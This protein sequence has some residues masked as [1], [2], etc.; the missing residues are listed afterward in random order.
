MV[1]R[2]QYKNIFLTYAQADLGNDSL[3]DFLWDKVSTF[4]PKYL[5]VC[6]E[7]HKYPEGHELEGQDNEDEPHHHALIQ[8]SKK[9]NIFNS[10]YFDFADKHPKV[11]KAPNPEYK[12]ATLGDTRTYILK[13]GCFVERGEWVERGQKRNRDTVYAEALEASSRE[14]AEEII[15]AGA[16]RDYFVAAGQ[17]T[18]RL[19]ALYNNDEIRKTEAEYSMLQFQDIPEPIWSWYSNHILVSVISEGMM[20]KI[21]GGAPTP[22][23]VDLQH[24]RCA[25]SGPTRPYAF[26]GVCLIS[27]VY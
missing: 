7:Y 27:I 10:R 4:Q 12:H 23:L 3:A 11:E 20:W 17:I 26:V 24:P 19:N 21:A 1:F 6:K 15:R 16:P 18:N 14:E 2:V 22:P 13:D 9:P 25:R 8:L 5:V